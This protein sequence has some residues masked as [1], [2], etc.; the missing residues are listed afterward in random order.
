MTPDLKTFVKNIMSLFEENQYIG[1][2]DGDVDKVYIINAF[3]DEYAKSRNYSVFGGVSDYDN[4]KSYFGD[5]DDSYNSNSG[6]N[7]DDEFSGT[8]TNSHLLGKL[9]QDG[10]TER[11]KYGKSRP[12][13][14]TRITN[15]GTSTGDRVNKATTTGTLKESSTKIMSMM[16]TV[17]HIVTNM[18]TNTEPVNA[19]KQMPALYARINNTASTSVFLT[20]M[21]LISCL[22][23]EDDGFVQS[24]ASTFNE[25]KKQISSSHTTSCYSKTRK[26]WWL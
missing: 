13:D 23:Q 26:K 20:N 2:N 3:G 16:K 9:S 5:N 19:I 22:V 1:V 6:Y 25:I 7:E 10:V 4:D 8:L 11:R 14:F 17:K 15:D 12:D 18:K 21:N 24:G